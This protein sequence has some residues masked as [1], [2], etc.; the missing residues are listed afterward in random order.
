MNAERPRQLVMDLAG[1]PAMGRDDFIEAPAN[2]AARDC[3]ALPEWPTGILVLTGPAA[4]GKSH[5]AAIWAA[6]NTAVAY[7]AS[8]PALAAFAA[9][10]RPLVVTGCDDG[11]ADETAL[12][13]LANEARLGVARM[14]LTGEREPEF[15]RVST[16][17]LASRLRGALR[18]RIGDPDDALVEALFVKHC[19][20]RQLEIEAP[21]LR[22]AL[23]RVERSYAFVARVVA[24]LDEEAMRQRRAPSRSLLLSILADMQQS[25]P[26]SD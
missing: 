14:L 11:F 3:L 19:A 5:L 20:D 22:S 17:D 6:D 21:A 8:D 12:F 4:S 1:A 26:P 10:T 23:A 2:Q 18:A 24:R 15:W 16:P 25:E 13:H 9:G 7:A